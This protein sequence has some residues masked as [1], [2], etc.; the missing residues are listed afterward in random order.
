MLLKFEKKK[1]KTKKKTLSLQGVVHQQEEIRASKS[2]MVTSYDVIL[3]QK[4]DQENQYQK[5]LSRK[6]PF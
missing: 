6:L 1:Q 5:E 4:K 3:N 2:V